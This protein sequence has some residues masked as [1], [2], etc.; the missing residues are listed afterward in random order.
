MSAAQNNG[1]RPASFTAWLEQWLEKLRWQV[2]FY[3]LHF[4]EGDH[5]WGQLRW[6]AIVA[7]VLTFVVISRLFESIPS[8]PLFDWVIDNLGLREF[9]PAPALN[10]AAVVLSF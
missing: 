9:I 7:V 2:G 3:V 10:L 4:V 8:L 1:A 5:Q 6:T